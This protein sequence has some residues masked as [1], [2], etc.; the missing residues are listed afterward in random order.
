MDP[1]AR[2]RQLLDLANSGEL[3]LDPEI[4][5]DLDAQCAAYLDELDSIRASARSAEHLTGFGTMPS[6]PILEAK[7]AGKVDG[8]DSALCRSLDTHIDQVELMRQVFAKAIANYREADRSTAVRLDG[9][10]IPREGG[11]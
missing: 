10:E 2:W 5:R 4:G 6:G 11:R 7:F 8:P 9:I 3:Q 1:T